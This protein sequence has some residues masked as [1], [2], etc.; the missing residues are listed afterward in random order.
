RQARFTPATL[1]GQLDTHRL[2][3]FLTVRLAQCRDVEPAVSRSLLADE[4]TGIVDQTVDQRD[5]GGVHLGFDAVQLGHVAGHG[6]VCFEPAGGSIGS[7][8]RARVTRAGQRDAARTELSG[9]RDRRRQTAGLEAGGRVQALVL[10]LELPALEAQLPGRFFSYAYQWCQAFAQRDDVG[11]VS[12]RQ[13]LPVPPHIP[14]P[15]GKLSRHDCLADAVQVVAR[16]EHLAARRADRL[17]LVRV[18]TQAA[19][20]ALEV[21]EVATPDGS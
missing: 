6:Q 15:A 21:G 7:G 2:L 12:D 9:A 4:P 3:A 20:G 11:G 17:Q 14:A 13:E 1:L 5:V 16:E 10:E 8:S 19:G 18:V